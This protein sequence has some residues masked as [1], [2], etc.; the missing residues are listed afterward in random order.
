MLQMRRH[1]ARSG[2]GAHDG[3]A[4]HVGGLILARIE[5]SRGPS[6]GPMMSAPIAWQI[7]PDLLRHPVR[8]P[9]LVLAKIEGHRAARAGRKRRCSP[10]R[11]PENSRGADSS[12]PAPPP[13]RNARTNRHWPFFQAVPQ[14]GVPGGVRRAPIGRPLVSRRIDACAAEK[15]QARMIEIVVVE[16]VDDHRRA[17]GGQKRIDPAICGK[18]HPTPEIVW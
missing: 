5:R 11:G 15:R 17:A 2:V 9:D 6:T 4:G 14:R 1:H 7:S 16:L 3:A 12:C 18:I 13:R 10:G 8:H